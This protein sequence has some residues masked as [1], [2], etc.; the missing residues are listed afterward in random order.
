MF[1][2]SGVPTSNG[3]AR[4]VFGREGEGGR[5]KGVVAQAGLLVTTPAG[6]AGTVR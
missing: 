6:L 2:F 1:A 3:A 4:A 5:V